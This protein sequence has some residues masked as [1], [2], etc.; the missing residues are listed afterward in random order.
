MKRNR[1]GSVLILALWLSSGLA[2]TALMFGHTGM[3]EYRREGNLLARRE[4][5]QAVAG[6]LRYLQVALQSQTPGRLPTA[7][8]VEVEDLTIGNCRVWIIG[9]GTS[10]SADRP[11]FGLQ[12]EASRLNLN[13]AT[14]AMLETLPSMPTELAAA[15]LDWRDPDEEL[16]VGGAESSTYLARTPAFVAK[17]GP[18]ETVEELRL[19]HGAERLALE[20]V[21]RDRNGIIETWER[22]LADQQKERL[23]SIPDRG[24]LDLVTIASRESNTRSDGRPKTSLN[25]NPQQVT[26][27][28]REALG[29]ERG[30]TVVA[31]AGIGSGMS[32]RSLLEFGIRAELTDEEFEKIQEVLTTVTGNMIPG[33]VNVNTAGVEV[34]KCIPGIGESNAGRLISYRTQFAVEPDDSLLWVARAI[35][36]NAAIEAGPYLTNRSFQIIADIVAVHGSSRVF[37]R[38]R[39]VLDLSTGTAVVAGCRDLSALGW[40]LGQALRNELQTDMETDR[41]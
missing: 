27:A 16:T 19:L 31:A 15:I 20:G 26:A 5:D 14:L 37:R 22:T 13:T 3:L 7:E 4:A 38:M 41:K 9:Q 29:A 10:S 23:Q 11:V 35:D 12:D 1:K 40:P 36:E 6:T 28:L 18:F 34:L 30:A 25:G 39:Y 21:D 24:L 33:R 8:E 32:Y 2:A 17:N